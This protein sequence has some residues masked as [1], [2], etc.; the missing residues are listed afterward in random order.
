[1][2]KT[3][4]LSGNQM[5]IEARFGFKA[6]RFTSTNTWLAFLG[7]AILAGAWYGLMKLFQAYSPNLIYLYEPFL[8]HGNLT[9]VIPATFLFFTSCVILFVKGRKVSL[10]KKAFEWG[11]V[12]AQ[13]EFVLTEKTAHSFYG[14]NFPIIL[15]GCGA[16]AY[17]RELGL[18][19]FDDVVNHGYDRIP[20]PFDRIVT[21]IDANRRLLT[22]ANYAKQSWAYCQS[23]FKSNVR[24]MHDI[25]S[26][27]ENRTRQKFAETLELIG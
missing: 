21:A 26:L 6:G 10:Q 13:L 1:M 16:V 22:D 9:T 5:D 24:V 12:P 3:S 7:G 2:N 27:Y 19:L 14:C 20:N 11:V 4:A 17:L 18:D 23:R 25:Y 15:S 8:R